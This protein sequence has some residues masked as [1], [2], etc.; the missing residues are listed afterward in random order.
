M[1][2]VVVGPFPSVA[3]APGASVD[4]GVAVLGLSGRACGMVGRL[5]SP[6]E[7]T[8]ASVVASLW[9]TAV[10]PEGAGKV[11]LSVGWV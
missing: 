4:H 7:G 9:D 11:V 8:L 2:R 5:A 10:V 6:V 3:V 1:P